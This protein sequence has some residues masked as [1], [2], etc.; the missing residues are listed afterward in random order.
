MKMERSATC[1]CIFFLLP[2]A[3]LCWQDTCCKVRRGVCVKEVEFSSCYLG[4]HPFRWTAPQPNSSMDG[5][6]SDKR[7]CFKWMISVDRFVR[8]CPVRCSYQRLHEAS[9]E[10]NVHVDRQE[11]EDKAD[12]A[13]KAGSDG[14]WE[15]FND[16]HLADDTILFLDYPAVIGLSPA[17]LG[18]IF[19]IVNCSPQSLRYG[20]TCKGKLVHT[21][22]H[23][24]PA[25]QPAGFV[26]SSWVGLVT[27]C[28]KVERSSMPGE[29]LVRFANGLK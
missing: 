9:E 11:V 8:C 26:V 21:A 29:T 17:G 10:R 25:H 28:L 14:E 16:F 2:F 22:D 3:V 15:C 1:K 4:G 6:R 12:L 19:C 23:L 24:L 7:P 20:L 13:R 27:S 5:L 18:K